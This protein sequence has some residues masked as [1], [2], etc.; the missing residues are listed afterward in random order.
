MRICSLLPSATEILCSLGLADQLVAVTHECDYPSEITGLPRI[1]RSSIPPG[2][3]S[4]DV[5]THIRQARHQGSSIYQLDERLLQEL[6]PDLILTQELCDVCAVSYETVQ[7]AVRLLDG[8]RRI[9]SLEPTR[10]DEI[11]MSIEQV[12]RHTGR[13]EAAANLVRDLRERLRRV[14]SHADGVRTRPRVLALEWFEPPFVG[15]HWV[16]EMIRLAG[17]LD[18]LGKA[19]S[20]SSEISW[21]EVLRY[22]P[23]VVVGLP[24][25]FDLEECLRGFETVPFPAGWE[26]TQAHRSGRVYAVN[27]SAYFNRPGPRIVEGLEILGEILHPELFPPNP[28]SGRWRRLS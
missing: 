19:G 5:D 17:G 15:G 23:E 14:A 2:G 16:P 4:R 13:E 27:A 6:D 1:T 26:N 24:C 22:D 12:G 3:S 9:L 7:K 21:Q 8:E 28:S 18:L 20:P 10:V 11:L 25:G